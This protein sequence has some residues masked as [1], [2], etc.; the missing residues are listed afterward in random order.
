M[1]L[2]DGD[3]TSSRVGPHRTAVIWLTTILIGGCSTAQSTSGVPGGLAQNGLDGGRDGSVVDG[4]PDAGKTL[5]CAPPAGPNDATC[6][7]PPCPEWRTVPLPDHHAIP[8]ALFATRSGRVF[9]HME[10]LVYSD[11]L[12]GTW[13]QANLAMPLQ[14][15]VTLHE[16]G[17]GRLLAAIDRE[18]TGRADAQLF[19]SRTGGDSWSEVSTASVPPISYAAITPQGIYAFDG[20]SLWQTID[21]GKAWVRVAEFWTGSWEDLAANRDGFV[22]MSTLR[23]HPGQDRWF[24]LASVFD[25]ISQF[26]KPQLATDTG[27]VF[28]VGVDGLL[29]SGDLGESWNIIWD[30]APSA[31][32]A[33]SNGVVA[34][35]DKTGVFI[36]R[37]G[38]W[39][40]VGPSL[41]GSFG[42]VAVLPD[43]RGAVLWRPSGEITRLSVMT[44]PAP[45]TPFPARNPPACHDGKRSPG[46]DRVDCGGECLPCEDWEVL[47]LFRQEANYVLTAKDTV[48]AYKHSLPLDQMW[49]STDQGRTWSAVADPGG[50][51]SAVGS[52]TTLPTAAAA[53][54]GTVYYAA[55]G[56]IYASTDDAVSF[57][58]ANLAKL[59]IQIFL[60]TTAT[61][62]VIFG[63]VQM[64][65]SSDHGATWK[66]IDPPVVLPA[67]TDNL[68]ALRSGALLTI[69]QYNHSQYNHLRSRDDG[70]TWQS[71]NV[72]WTQP[73][74][75]SLIG[76]TI[77]SASSDALYVSEDEGDTWIKVATPEAKA[78]LFAT[79]SKR[80]IFTGA[81]VNVSDSPG[82]TWRVAGERG[83]LPARSFFQFKDG[84]LFG[85]LGAP[86]CVDE[87]GWTVRAEDPAT[88]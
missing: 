1:R 81:H 44:A 36:Y 77:V 54:D 49:R 16:S 4:A 13:K 38:G 72:P 48:V 51:W 37:D 60:V 46:E 55:G 86:Y 87:C 32:A 42:G 19:V 15:T 45:A 8:E 61:N 21:D 33:S 75:C 34:A 12:D 63:G 64:M 25:G 35:V 67:V 26:G 7:C 40:H 79:A 62:D 66:N 10:T 27:A 20:S 78:Q 52:T 59:P 84:R 73:V 29:A 6:G 80:Y 24:N 30:K 39:P 88:W 53:S 85:Q 74:S 22:F 47:P 65:R 14:M 3:V 83:Y 18:Q 41:S 5:A 28:R 50:T 70:D 11:T 68:V 56:D 9:V 23:Y 31:L 2:R 71:L 69:S 82:T 58:K 57:H 17:D 76:P 43:G